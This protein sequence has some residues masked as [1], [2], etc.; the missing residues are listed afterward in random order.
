MQ[1]VRLTEQLNS[2]HKQL[3]DLKAKVAAKGYDYNKLEE[4]RNARATRRDQ[5]KEYVAAVLEGKEV[6]PPAID[7]PQPEP[8]PQLDAAA[9][10]PVDPSPPDPIPPEPAPPEPVDFWVPPAGKSTDPFP[11]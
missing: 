11:F 8:A 2:L 4:E 7:A 1:E 10:Q 6:Q 5:I 9:P 3:E